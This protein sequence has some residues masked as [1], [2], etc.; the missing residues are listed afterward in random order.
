MGS[1]P[2]AAFNMVKSNFV[3]FLLSLSFSL[4]VQADPP[5]VLPQGPHS[6]VLGQCSSQVV[7]LEAAT[8]KAYLEKI[9]FL[10]RTGSYCETVSLF[11]I[12]V[13]NWNLLVIN[14]T[15]EELGQGYVDAL[16]A[17]TKTKNFSP[18]MV[19]MWV[20][21]YL[22]NIPDT[23]PDKSILS[24][25]LRYSVEVKHSRFESCELGREI[26]DATLQETYVF[27]EVY[28]LSDKRG[29]WSDNA[30]YVLGIQNEMLVC[31]AMKRVNEA[32]YMFMP[33]SERGIKTVFHSRGELERNV[34]AA[35]HVYLGI[36]ESYREVPTPEG[37]F[38]E[39]VSTFGELALARISELPTEFE[40]KGKK[41]RHNWMKSAQA[42]LKQVPLPRFI[43]QRAK[44]AS[45][46]FSAKIQLERA[47]ILLDEKKTEAAT[48]LLVFITREFSENRFVVEAY[49]E[50][51]KLQVHSLVSLNW[52]GMS[53]SIIR[54]SFDS[55][56]YAKAKSRFFELTEDMG[57]SEGNL[58][59]SNEIKMLE[60]YLES[61]IQKMKNSNV[62]IPAEI[63]DIQ[64]VI[65]EIK[66]LQVAQ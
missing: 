56:E 65:A 10:V 1:L 30:Q 20:N 55:G 51:K 46:I 45:N 31:L 53:L 49:E 12:L 27:E 8:S 25:I 64:E 58:P 43:S 29:I 44:E 36:I 66:K 41:Q 37:E 9:N 13:Q 33:K 16:S 47:R 48:D 6:I 42:L 52:G 21:N 32:K 7:E 61:R 62:G 18:D 15:P 24:Q 2:D 54:L 39:D 63:K 11:G 17:V 19:D 57:V 35:G 4:S 34:N 22:A 60:D 14:H 26:I 28:K 5:A 3:L 59:T 40:I 38:K 23:T 50:L